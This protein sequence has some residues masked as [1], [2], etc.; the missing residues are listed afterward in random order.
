MTD[1][2]VLTMRQRFL[3]DQELAGELRDSIS[4]SWR[5]S[6]ALAVDSDTV[7][8][9]F[10]RE[11]ELDSPLAAAARPVMRDLADGLASDPISV[12]LTSHD[13]VVLSRAAAA[14]SLCH[15]L[16]SV[17]LAPGFSY[18]EEFVGTNGIGTTLETRKP[19]MVIGA[20][21]YCESLVNLACAGAPIFD[22]VS[23]ALLGAVDL[24]G[25]VQ[26]GGGLMSTL[27][28]SAAAR[29]EDRLLEQA[30][31]SH[32]ALLNEFA[33]VCRRHA[34]VMVVAL[35]DDLVLTNQKLRQRLDSDDQATLL[36]YA[37]DCVGAVSR[38]RVDTLPS[39]TTVRLTR[40]D[41]ALDGMG[42]IFAVHVT[43]ATLRRALAATGTP[44]TLPGLAG[45]S[46]SWRR[47]TSEVR[48]ALETSQW[49]AVAGE[50]GVGRCAVL[51]GAA[52]LKRSGSVRSF[53]PGDLAT[54]AGMTHLEDEL[55]RDGFNVILRDIDQLD[56]ATVE[57]LV[58][59]LSGR[60]HDGWV[61]VTLGPDNTTTAVEGL[62]LPFFSRTVTIPALRFRLDD[63]DD[64]VPLLLR[65][66]SRGDRLTLSPAAMRQL[67]KFGWPGNVAQLR[68]ILLSVVR[69]QYSGV[70]EVDDLP[71]VCR[72]FARH[73]LSRIEALERDEIVRSLTENH[74]NKQKA[75]QSLGISR[76]TIYRKIKQFRIAT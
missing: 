64:L 14:S 45:R 32:I 23:G 3:A 1:F 53:G 38:S 26:H 18:S 5:R 42:A 8:L 24:T 54:P 11:P 51:R 21:H 6:K 48:R 37:A 66:L 30:S 73:R 65:Q 76:A 46:S 50:P 4:M 61:G 19:T 41:T 62:L 12:I 56:D 40:V 49:I 33:A 16:D 67:A 35:G 47:A 68:E 39:G 69:Q 29:I 2:D 36:D 75:A 70:V 34:G 55:D 28:V 13:G 31:A 44:T 7:D 17:H 72:T 59:L 63:L 71:P 20:E 9:A 57:Q 27:A 22:P 58:D 10:I 25:W 52:E 43:E 60:E 74:F 15:D